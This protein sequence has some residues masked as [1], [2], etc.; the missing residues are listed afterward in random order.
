MTFTEH[1]TSPEP[2]PKDGGSWHWWPYGGE[3]RW[4]AYPERETCG[5]TGFYDCRCGGDFCCCG[6]DGE[7]ECVGCADCDPEDYWEDYEE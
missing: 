5:G 4:C 1:P 6:N 7:I 3:W 2:A